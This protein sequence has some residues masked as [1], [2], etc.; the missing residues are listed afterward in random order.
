MQQKEPFILN[1]KRRKL[2]QIHHV[3]PGQLFPG[4]FDGSGSIFVK[5][6]YV[7]LAA[8]RGIVISHNA[9][10]VVFPAQCDTGR[11]IG[12]IP[13]N[14]PQAEN[15]VHGPGRDVRKDRR[16]GF[17]ICVN[18][19]KNNY[20]PHKS[21]P[22]SELLSTFQAA[23]KGTNKEKSTDVYIPTLNPDCQGTRLPVQTCQGNRKRVFTAS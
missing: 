9:E 14:I 17:E 15:F 1:V 10:D 8:Y 3:V 19:G 18:V 2:I 7:R 23:F 11:R 6:P 20:F 13:D 21:K 22:S 12:I 4:P 16:E 5:R